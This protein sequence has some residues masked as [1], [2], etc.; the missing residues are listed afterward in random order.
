VK[1][2]SLMSIVVTIVAALF[3]ATGSF[4]APPAAF[5]PYTTGRDIFVGGTTWSAVFLYANAGDT[6]ELYELVAPPTGLIF[7]NNDTGSYPIGMTQTYSGYTNGQ[8]LTFELQD[9][10]VPAAWD[11]GV[12]STNVSYLPFASVADVETKFDVTL[13]AA[14]VTSLTALSLANPGN[15]LIVGFEDRLLATSDKD[16]N[17]LIFA[18]APVSAPVPEPLTILFLGAGL[19][20]LGVAARRRVKK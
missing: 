10:T 15:V 13:A 19:V 17:D 7:R 12:G 8:L 16:F 14:A 2:K 9:L 4:A 5:A 3:F 11:T 20:S 1:T 6:S 18:F